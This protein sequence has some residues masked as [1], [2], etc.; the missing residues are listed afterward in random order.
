MA[1]HDRPANPGGPWGGTLYKTTGPP[2]NAVPFNPAAV[3]ATPVG[4]ATL[5]FT[6][7]TDGTFSYTVDGV[8]QS[9]AITRQVFGPQP[10]CVSGAQSDQTLATNYQDLWW[11]APASSESGWGINLNHQ[12]DTIFATWFTYAVDGTPMWLVVTANLATPSVYAGTLYRTVGSPFSAEPFD[13]TRVAAQAVGTATFTFANGNS[14]TFDYNVNTAAGVV[15]QT[16][17][18]V[19]EVYAA[20]GT[21]CQ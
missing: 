4:S 11:A 5:A 20:P 6:D 12:G 19:R 18:I 2:F 8:S 10:V 14:A 9:K 13:P 21:V 3:H 16:K 17:T 7:A 15:H 1:R